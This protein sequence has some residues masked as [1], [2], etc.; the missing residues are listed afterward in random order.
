MGWCDD[1]VSAHT[2]SVSPVCQV[3]LAMWCTCEKKNLFMLQIRTGCEVVCAFK[4]AICALDWIICACRPLNA[5]FRFISLCTWATQIMLWMYYCLLARYSCSQTM[6]EGSL[7][8][9]RWFIFATLQQKQ[10]SRLHTCKRGTTSSLIAFS[11]CCA[12]HVAGLFH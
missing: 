11:F 10:Q 1:K 3:V 6:L 8:I 5:G 12:S 7:I 4:L 9:I 2:I